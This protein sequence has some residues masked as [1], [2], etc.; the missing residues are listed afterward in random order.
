MIDEPTL[1]CHHN[2]LV[3]ALGIQEPVILGEPQLCEAWTVKT[4]SR[5]T[6][7]GTPGLVFPAASFHS[8][9]SLAATFTTLGF[10]TTVRIQTPGS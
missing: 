10:Y 7:L 3:G 2:P 5:A 9:S 4:Q 8:F 6:P 1:R